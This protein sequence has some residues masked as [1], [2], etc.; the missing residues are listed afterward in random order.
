MSDS[1]IQASPAPAVPPRSKSSASARIALGLYA[2]L[3]VYASCYPFAGW[4]DTGLLPWAWLAEPMPRYWTVFDLVVNVIGYVPLGALLMLSLH[5]ALRGVRAMLVAAAAG[6]LLAAVLESLQSYLPS[7]VPSNLDLITN[8]TGTL[9]GVLVGELLRVPLLEQSWLRSLREHW[10]SDQASHGL[11]IVGLWPLAQIYPQPYLF[12]HGQLLPTLSAWVSEWSDEPIDLVQFVWRDISISIEQYL[13]A[14]VV[15]TALGMTAAV[16]TLLCQTRRHAPRTLLA[17]GLMLA[18]VAVKAL[19]HAVL[20]APDDAFS[21]LTPSAA[22]GLLVG[23]VMLG[24]LSFAP[25]VAQRR[26]AVFALTTC[27]LLLNMLPS[28]PYFLSTLQEWV[29]G[30]FLNFNGAAQFLSLVWPAF[31]LWFLLHPAHRTPE[32]PGV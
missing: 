12:G 19:A 29:Q 11:I 24:G 17:F 10:F 4:R 15:I 9:L 14:E 18:A 5:P 1:L 25:P 3:I 32:A 26:A 13:V 30:K 2:L 23:T 20:F 21:W 28:N 31:G 22:S 8:A 6:I 27:L 16:L 7:R